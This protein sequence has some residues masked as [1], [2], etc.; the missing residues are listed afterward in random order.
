[1]SDRDPALGDPVVIRGELVGIELVTDTARIK[2]EAGTIAVPRESVHELSNADI[3]SKWREHRDANVRR[4][5]A[6]TGISKRDFL[7][8]YA[9]AAA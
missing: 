8:G 5:L 3:E 6:I 9:A 2:T 4:G 1:M 7:A